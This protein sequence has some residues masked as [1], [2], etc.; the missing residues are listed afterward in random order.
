M[1]PLALSV[2]LFDGGRRAANVGAAQ[3]RLE[4]A[5]ALYGARVL[6]AVRE[7]EQALVNLQS[8][9]A[10][11]D[12]TQTAALGY[13]AA[14]DAAQ[15]RFNAGLSSLPELEDARRTSLAADT[16]Q[17]SLKRDRTLAWIALYRAAGGG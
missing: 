12:D 4:E 15:A 6:H 8:T 14:F 2:P 1:G 5:Q 11:S 7:V 16:V 13:R 17:L 9:A 10:R 3:S